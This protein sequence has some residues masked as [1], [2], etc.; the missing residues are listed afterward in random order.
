MTES[1]L[2]TL[3]D[4]HVADLLESAAEDLR[5]GDASRRETVETLGALFHAEDAIVVSEGPL[6]G[7]GRL[8][9]GRERAG[10][11]GVGYWLPGGYD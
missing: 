9:F 8:S 4:D 11:D 1:P 6:R 3:S 7:E 2:P 5:E 10:E